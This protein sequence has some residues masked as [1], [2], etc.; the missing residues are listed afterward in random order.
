MTD[1]MGYGKEKRRA[2][3]LKVLAG[4][5]TFRYVALPIGGNGLA[6]NIAA[7]IPSVRCWTA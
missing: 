4:E 1:N 6:V 2:G 3:N 5:A 7:E